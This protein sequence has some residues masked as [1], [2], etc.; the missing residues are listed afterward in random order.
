[1]RIALYARV[2]A[3]AQEKQQTIGSQ[4]AELRRHA[5]A[6]GLEIAREFVD[7]GYSG[8]ILERPGLYGVTPPR[9]GA[10]EANP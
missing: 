3:E 7:D 9:D 5:Q 4:L 8:T 6:N 1:M 2:S 10:Q